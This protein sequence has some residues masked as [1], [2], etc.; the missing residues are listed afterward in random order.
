[1]DQTGAWISL[2][3]GIAMMLVA[4]L[5][6][7]MRRR[8]TGHDWDAIFSDTRLIRLARLQERIGQA[9]LAAFGLGFV[10]SSLG[11]ILQFPSTLIWILSLPCFAA[12][13]GTAIAQLVII[14]RSR[15]IP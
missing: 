15:R 5:M 4:L 12:G 1:M 11:S 8:V 3:G 2:V 10:V 6:P 13:V 9:T 14:I 7:Q